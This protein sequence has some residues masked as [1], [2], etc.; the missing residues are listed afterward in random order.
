MFSSA[1]GERCEK[2]SQA[3]YKMA[4]ADVE[5]GRKI[6][7]DDAKKNIQ[8]TSKPG[9]RDILGTFWIRSHTSGPIILTPSG[10]VTAKV[11]PE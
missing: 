8:K 9:R 11:G 4:D 6:D 10:S 3:S 1:L 5:P 7:A 2:L